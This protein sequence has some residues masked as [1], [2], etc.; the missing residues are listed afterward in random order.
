MHDTL[1]DTKVTYERLEAEFGE[2]I[3]KLVDGV[4][5]LGQIDQ[6]SGMSERNIKEISRK[7]PR[8]KACA[9]CFWPW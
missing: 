4:T 2:G 5:K 6:L 1:E 7:T 3:A 8:L 9:R